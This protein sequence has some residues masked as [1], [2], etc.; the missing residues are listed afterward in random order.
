[1]KLLLMLVAMRGKTEEERQKKA[2]LPLLR[3]CFSQSRSSWSS[4][5]SRALTMGE[6]ARGQSTHWLFQSNL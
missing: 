6:Y 2:F 5:F 1:M 3:R 4:P